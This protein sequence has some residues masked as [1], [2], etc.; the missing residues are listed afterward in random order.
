[1][2]LIRCAMCKCAL[3]NQ[4]NPNESNWLGANGSKAHTSKILFR[5]LRCCCRLC[6]TGWLGWWRRY[7]WGWW[8]RCVGC[9]RWCLCH[10]RTFINANITAFAVVHVHNDIGTFARLAIAT[11]IIVIIVIV[12]DDNND[13]IFIIIFSLFYRTFAFAIGRSTGQLNEMKV[14]TKNCIK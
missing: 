2:Y 8:R 5:L 14:K 6:C 4:N 7:G 11:F 9:R 12:I 10:W 3:L 13:F 1:M